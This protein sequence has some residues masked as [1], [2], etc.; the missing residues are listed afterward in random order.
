M[1]TEAREGVLLYEN[2]IQLSATEKN[3]GKRNMFNQVGRND[4]MKRSFVTF[5]CIST[6]TF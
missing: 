5:K 1:L 3:T 4:K 2:Y 6:M